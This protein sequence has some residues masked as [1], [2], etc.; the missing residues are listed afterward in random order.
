MMNSIL[1]GI[2]N[3]GSTNKSTPKPSHS[4]H[5][6]NGE[7]KENNLG[8]ISSIVKPLSGQ[9]NFVENINFSIFRYFLGKVSSSYSTNI[10]PLAKFIAVSILSANL[11]PKAELRTIL[12]TNIEISCFI[13]LFSSGISSIL[14]N[15]TAAR[16]F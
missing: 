12:S 7:L 8:S 10:K 5:A 13:F 16:V 3:L 15:L 6:P 4:V 1:I 11:F 2:T 14:Y 9:A